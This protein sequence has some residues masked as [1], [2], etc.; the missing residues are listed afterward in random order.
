MKTIG[1]N[2]I[3]AIA[4]CLP[5]ILNAQTKKLEKTYSANED[6]EVKIDASHTNINVDYWDKDK[7]E[8]LA[9]FNGNGEHTRELLENWKVKTSGSRNMIKITSGGGMNWNGNVDL[10]GLEE[11]MAKLPEL[12]EPLLEHLITPLVEN[13]SGSFPANFSENM[14]QVKFDYEAYKKDGDKYI[15]KFEKEVETNLG[16]D[17]EKDMEKW[18]AKFEQNAEKW[19]KDF[20]L[21]MEANGK[22]IEKAMEKWAASF[23]TDMEAW[24]ES[25]GKQMEA[26]LANSQNESDDGAVV[27]D[28]SFV[29]NLHIKMPKNGKLSLDVRHGKVNLSGTSKNLNAKFSH[30][31]LTA[32]GITGNDTKVEAAYTPVRINTWDYGVLEAKYVNEFKIKCVKSIK[33]ISNSSNVH[34]GKLEDTGILSGNFGELEI[35]N[36]GTGFKNLD[37]NL[38][39][40]ELQLKLPSS[41]FNF[42]YT[43]TQSSINHPGNLKLT[44]RETYDNKKL[45]GYHKNKNTG[46]NIT[47][48]AN[49]SNVLLN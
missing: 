49:L 39:N 47:I 48:S 18:A 5:L 24:G 36:L 10:S 11:P 46:A 45:T 15:A 43:G 41:A 25:F 17:F 6:V 16:E 3:F 1:Y 28:Q 19:G 21:K 29:K 20:E 12:L 44:A 22:E 27:F 8:I 13:M 30:S 34:I 32:A 40:S 23:E 4:F 7:V 31:N 35:E 38:E 33:L 2:L 37:I 26:R 9:T 14:G 42:M